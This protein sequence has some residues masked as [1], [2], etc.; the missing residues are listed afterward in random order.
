[1]KQCYMYRRTFLKR[2]GIIG[3]FVCNC[4]PFRAA[5]GEPD[6]VAGSELR[7]TTPPAL[8]NP[9]Y[10]ALTIAIGVNKSS[11]AW[12]EYGE[13]EQLGKVSTGSRHGLKPFDALVHQI[14][15]HELRPGQRYFY[16]VHACAVEFKSAYDIRRG[17]TIATDI[18]TFSVLDPTAKAASFVVWN[19]THENTETMA[20]LMAL[21]RKLGADFHVWNGDITNDNY[22]EAKM[23]EHYIG[24]GGQPF[25]RDVPL[26]FVRG[27]HD[28]RGPAARFL[29]RFQ[30]TPE[31]RFYYGFRHG[32]LAGVVLDSG[33]DKPDTTPVYAGLGDFIAYHAEQTAWLKAEVSKPYLR[34]APFRIAFC[35]IPLWW[36][37]KRYP[38]DQADPRW[39]WDRILAEAG[40][41][42]VISGHTHS[43]AMLRPDKDR[44]YVQVIGGGPK[45][46]NA[47]LIYG[48][49]ASAELRISIIN[50]QGQ[51]KDSYAIL[52]N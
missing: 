52:R 31:G 51:E 46:E 39:E 35:H 22:T 15:I 12:V 32:P 2:T 10:N 9:S 38:E 28:T 43:H 11:T 41:C 16:R 26:L 7:F 17:E 18:Y 8:Q 13:T 1:M 44:K 48:H 19:D 4:V 30:E 23:A 40:F 3:V 5:A 45:P 42:A 29:P 21:T 34:N 27:N 49:A 25:A 24:A 6:A 37:D 47:T 36:G 14:R 50:A 20:N 33:E